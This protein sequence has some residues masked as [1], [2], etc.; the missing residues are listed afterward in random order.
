M[1]IKPSSEIEDKMSYKINPNL[2]FVLMA[3]GIMNL[4][5][6]EDSQEM[7]FKQSNM[8]APKIMSYHFGV[9]TLPIADQIS[10]LVDLQMDGIILQIETNSL[11]NLEKYYESY[12]VK[13]GKF[14]IY[15]IFTS[16]SLDNQEEW[17]NQ[18]TTIEEIYKKIENKKTVLQVIFRGEKGNINTSTIISNIAKIARKYDKIL[19][20]YPHEGNAIETAE[21]A[22]IYIKAT[23]QDNVF[24][25]V[26]LCHELAAGNGG[27]IE[28]VISNVAEYIKSV[29]ISGATESEQFDTN[30]PLWFWAIKPLNMGN[31]DYKNY[32][33]AL[34]KIDYKRPIAIH[35]WGMLNNFGLSPKDHLPN[36]KDILLAL[37]SDVCK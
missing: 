29:S 19:V 36:S 5:S 1:T 32:F 8:C 20:I 25:S 17:E 12:E 31:Y 15:D 3:I 37:G 21:E 7:G 28:E 30:L 27:R 10:T 6:C 16:F 18:M 24:L 26:H 34:Y 11:Q 33:N 14:H 23:N 2:R 35:T 4:I 13:S 9:E 22:L